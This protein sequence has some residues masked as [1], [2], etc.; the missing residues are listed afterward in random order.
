MA[1]PKADPKLVADVWVSNPDGGAPQCFTA[2]TAKSALPVWALGEIGNPFAWDNAWRD[3]RVSFIALPRLQGAGAPQDMIDGVLEAFQEARGTDD[4]ETHVADLLALTSDS[5]RIAEAVTSY[6]QATEQRGGKTYEDHVAESDAAGVPPVP[7][8][9]WLDT[10]DGVDV[11]QAAVDAHTAVRGGETYAQYVERAQV[12][13]AE[14]VD[15]DTFL[16][17]PDDG[18]AVGFVEPFDPEAAAAGSKDDFAA[19]VNTDTSGDFAAHVEKQ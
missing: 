19:K 8:V 6:R 18:V 5:N 1:R 11:E 13:D 4:Y 16:S 3:E 15:I 12:A 14:P 17:S 7:F 9:A 2:G 10:S